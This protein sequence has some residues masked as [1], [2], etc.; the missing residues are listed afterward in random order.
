[1]R[2]P[3]RVFVD[4]AEITVKAGNGGN[5]AVSFRREKYVPKGGPDGGN[6]GDGGSV[7]LAAD[8]NVN[9][10][11]DFRGQ[12]HWSAKDG[13]AGR[14]KQQSGAAGADCVIR[15]PP[16]TL[17]HDARDGTLLCD[18]KPGDRVIIAK[19]GRGGFGNEHFKRSTNQT[20]RKSEP[21]EHG[22]QLDLRLELKLIAEVGI[23]GLPN[24]GKSTLLAALTR[25]T[26]KIADYP[27]TTLSP[28]LGIAELDQTRR[29]IFADIPGLIEG[30]AHGAGLGHDFLRHVERTRVL[31]HL[32]DV[33]PTDETDP[34]ENYRKIRAELN[35]YSPLLAE[36]QEVIAL[37]KMDLIPDGAEQKKLVPKICRK[38]K[39]GHNEPV[40]AISGAARQ[41]M[42]DLLE[43]LWLMLHP[44][45]SKVEGWKPVPPTSPP[46]VA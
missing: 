33:A 44:V 31:L 39:L 35:E 25:A 18:L 41:G 5:G 24:A 45:D 9:T 15:M 22:P 32:L 28:Q 7:I 26:P 29:I 38:L 34:V 21:G 40:L 19:G 11:F 43:R 36:K 2:L 37:N 1:M 8:G 27:F 4:Q 16:G 6:G 13:E 10:L 46:V 12:H 3:S 14:A 30:A 20:P 42:K 23:I 17:V